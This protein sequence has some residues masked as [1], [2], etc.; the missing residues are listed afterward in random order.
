MFRGCRSN[1]RARSRDVTPI[2]HQ[3]KAQANQDDGRGAAGAWPEGR[4]DHRPPRTAHRRL[5]RRRRCRA[6]G[7][8]VRALRRRAR[9]AEGAAGDPGHVGCDRSRSGD[10]VGG[11]LRP[12]RH[13]ERRASHGGHDVP[14]GIGD[15]ADRRNADHA[16]GRGRDSRSRPTRIRLRRRPGERRCCHVP[17]PPHPHVGGRH[18]RDVVPLQ[19]QPVRAAG[20][21]DRGRYRNPVRRPAH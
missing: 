4:P 21:R 14:P 12:R 13:R 18:A 5:R 11:G 17:A 9:S 1:H 20:R 7:G 16:V 2:P 19:R 10:G 8:R 6:F 15:Q 3:G